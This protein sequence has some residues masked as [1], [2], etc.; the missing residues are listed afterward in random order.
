VDLG[1]KMTNVILL[2]GGVALFLYGISLMGDGLKKVAGSKMELILFKLSG[3]PVKGI[4]LGTGVTA[5]IQSSSATSV[6]VVGFVNSGMMKLKQA[7]P[8][9]MGSI[10]GTSITGW[11]ICLSEIGSGASGILSLFSTESLAAIVAIIGILIKYLSKKRSAN[12]VAAILFGFSI[13]MFGM[14]TMSGSVSD[15]KNNEAFIN[16]LVSFSN[17]AIGVLFGAA[18]TAILQSASAAVGIIQVLSITGVLQFNQAFPIIMGIAVGAAVPVLISAVGASVNAKRTAWSYL[19]INSMGS[20]I[21]GTLFYIVNGFAHFGF[22]NVTMN[23]A[24]IAALNTVFRIVMVVFLLPLIGLIEKTSKLIIKSN[25][26]DDAGSEDLEMLEERF[27]KYPPLAI[28]QSRLVINSMSEIVRKS[29]AD[30]I[31]LI[32]NY[33]DE[34][35]EEVAKL[36]ELGDKYEDKIGSYIMNI[37]RSELSPDQ[38]NA[39]T[40][41]LYAISDLERISD[42]AR[43]IAECAQEMVEKHIEF[44][45]EGTEDINLICDAI[46][47]V[48]AITVKAFET[49]DVELA[50]RIEPL[51]EVVDELCDVLKLHHS[52]RLQKGSCNIERGYI[53]NDLLINFER[54]SD[55]CS[56]VGAAMLELQSG[57]LEMHVYTDEVNKNNLHHFDEYYQEYSKKYLPK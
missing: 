15:L 36:E 2:L 8:V 37:T 35:F 38:G 40:K 51:E 21:V 14:K 19:L 18:F 22:M 57:D 27:L 33:S 23:S 55:H 25:P 34:G 30:S 1:E 16:I 49:N 46:N 47:E 17:P 44:T 50:Y 52:E 43:N 20:I 28:E 10:I 48:V 56:N 12:N 45:D 11:I 3:T 5:V 6:M 9:V 13:L 7:I 26:N 24:S 53:F 4:L 41:Y 42:H 29:I 54:V 32:G 31:A 39:I